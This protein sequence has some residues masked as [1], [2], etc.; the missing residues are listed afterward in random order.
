MATVFCS[1]PECPRHA[2]ESYEGVR[3]C[4]SCMS[5]YIRGRGD[6]LLAATNKMVECLANKEVKSV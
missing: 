5:A 6:A 1:T 4:R 3:F 2:H